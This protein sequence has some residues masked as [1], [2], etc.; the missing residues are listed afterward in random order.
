MSPRTSG[1]P[2]PRAF[3][4]GPPDSS[5]TGAAS[6]NHV[7]SKKDCWFFGRSAVTKAGGGSGTVSL[8]HAQL[9][10]CGGSWRRRTHGMGW[11]VSRKTSFPGIT[12]QRLT[13]RHKEGSGECKRQTWS[14]WKH[15]CSLEDRD[16]KEK[17]L[18]KP[19]SKQIAKPGEQFVPTEK[20]RIR[21]CT[22]QSWALLRGT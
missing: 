14:W 22:T 18:G 21:T 10:S 9:R 17:S 1:E 12:G 6:Q 20:K 3:L 19:R 8:W 16:I 15:L 11:E 4:W 7:P 13:V 2:K 5:R